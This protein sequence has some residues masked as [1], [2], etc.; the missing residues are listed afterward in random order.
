MQWMLEAAAARTN[1]LK[2]KNANMETDNAVLEAERIQLIEQLIQLRDIKKMISKISQQ[3]N[4]FPGL[5]VRM[6]F[7]FYDTHFY[8]CLLIH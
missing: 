1:E 2:E 3:E 8:L 4:G 6:P 5:T 7:Y